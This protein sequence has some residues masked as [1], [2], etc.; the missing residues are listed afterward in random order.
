MTENNYATCDDRCPPGEHVIVR[1]HT[2][3]R[4]CRYCGTHSQTLYSHP[5]G[6]AEGDFRVVCTEPDCSYG[7]FTDA[8][9]HGYT[10]HTSLVMASAA[11]DDHQDDSERTDSDGEEA[12][13]HSAKIQQHPVDAVT[14]RFPNDDADNGTH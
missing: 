6:A 8:N 12:A 9:G 3:G 4:I 13:R 5:K 2:G 7:H 14:D 1:A 10:N 11:L